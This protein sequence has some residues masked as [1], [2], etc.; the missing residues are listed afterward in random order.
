ME[1]KEAWA[2]Q[3]AMNLARSHFRRRAAEYR[4]RQRLSPARSMVVDEP[5]EALRSEVVD[6]VSRL[7]RR[8]RTALILRYYVDLSVAETAVV[9]QCPQN[10]VKTLARRALV[11]LRE[12]LN[13][14]TIKEESDATRY[15]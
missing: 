7:P 11:Q 14:E 12:L 15:P 3:V 1:S 9:M 8:Q 13:D 2:H 4:A 5:P 10:T 6:A